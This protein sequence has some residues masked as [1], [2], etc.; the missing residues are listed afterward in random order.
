MYEPIKRLTGV[1]NAFQQ[2]VGASEQVFQYLDVP[3]EIQDRPDA[4]VLPPFRREIAFEDVDFDYQRGVPLL[5]G[6]DLRIG[7]GE[8]VAIVGPSGAGKTTLAS[9]IPRFFDVTRGR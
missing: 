8:V 5:R 9:L 6:V 3:S 2:A 1:N 4:V 7:Q